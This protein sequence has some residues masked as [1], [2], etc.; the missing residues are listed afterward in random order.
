MFKRLESATAGTVVETDA[1]LAALPFDQNGLIA[2]V[3]QQF[4]TG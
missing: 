2:A 4:D 3:A 1:A